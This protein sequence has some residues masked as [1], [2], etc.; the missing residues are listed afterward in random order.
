[1]EG[2]QGRWIDGLMNGR[3]EGTINIWMDGC[4]DGWINGRREG[5]REEGKQEGN[6]KVWMHWWMDGWKKGRKDRCM[7]IWK[8]GWTDGQKEAE[9]IA[10][11]Y[12]KVRTSTKAKF[13]GKAQSTLS[14]CPHIWNLNG[15]KGSDAN[16]GQSQ[17][18]QMMAQGRW[19]TGFRSRRWC[20]HKE[21]FR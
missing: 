9:A 10:H 4:M 3:K 6:T 20:W 7:C 17:K 8:H 16:L 15:T 11:N 12:R 19:K 14:Q 1:M 2:R 18:L 21:F 5:R 13:T